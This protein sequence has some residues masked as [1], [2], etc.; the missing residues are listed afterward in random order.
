MGSDSWLSKN[1]RPV[2]LLASL[3]FVFITLVL[4]CAG[5]PA[6]ESVVSMI[7]TLA[8]SFVMVYCGSRGVEKALQIRNNKKK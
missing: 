3:S 5:Y 6:K 8:V 1:I 4:D 2:G 7:E